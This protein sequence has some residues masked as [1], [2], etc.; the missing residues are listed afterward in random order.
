MRIETIGRAAQGMAARS[1]ET[2][3]LGPQGNSPVPEGDAP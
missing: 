3:R 1:D 2:E